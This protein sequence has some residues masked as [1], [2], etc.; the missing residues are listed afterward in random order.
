M[1]DSTVDELWLIDGAPVPLLYRA[2]S[3]VLNPGR[4]WSKRSF[5]R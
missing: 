1:R 2:A 3:M 5:Y 4:F